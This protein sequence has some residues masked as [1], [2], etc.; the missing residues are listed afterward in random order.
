MKRILIAAALVALASP[1]YAA[2]CPRQMADIDKALP[3][4]KLDAAKKAQVQQLRA[5]GE[6]KH[7]AGQHADS[8]KDLQQAKQILGSM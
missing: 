8:A 1:A 5:S 3:T 4:A 7:K 6:T 2:S